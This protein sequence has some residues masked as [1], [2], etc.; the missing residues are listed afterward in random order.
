[1]VLRFFLYGDLTATVLLVAGLQKL[2]E[3]AVFAAI[4]ISKSRVINVAM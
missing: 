3:G 4:S 1:M 2:W